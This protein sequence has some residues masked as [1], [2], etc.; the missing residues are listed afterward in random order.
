LITDALAAR[1][2]DSSVSVPWSVFDSINAFNRWKA[3]ESAGRVFVVA[4]GGMA[5][6]QVTG[7]SWRTQVSAQVFEEAA[8][9]LG[10]ALTRYAQGGHQRVGF[11]RYKSKGRDRH[12]FR[13][14]SATVTR[15]GDRWYVSLNAEAADY[16]RAVRH[17][18]RS[19]TDRTF[20]GVDRGLVAFVVAAD[21]M[22]PRSAASPLPSR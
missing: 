5:T 7:L 18:P 17:R 22:A 6:K 8:V 12:S 11:P 16:H 9:D 2:A 3:S 13:L 1:T 14:R 20:V 10:R 4:P 21:Q 19:Q 15:R